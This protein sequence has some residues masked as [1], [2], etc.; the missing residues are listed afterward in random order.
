LNF[1][2]KLVLPAPGIDEVVE[3]GAVGTL[4]VAEHPQRGR[5]DVDA[6]SFAYGRTGRPEPRRALMQ[7]V[8][9]G[10]DLAYQNLD[11][12]GG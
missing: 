12:R 6:K 10:V 2:R 4:G 8:L 11:S 3:V 1:V 7:A 9:A 5:L